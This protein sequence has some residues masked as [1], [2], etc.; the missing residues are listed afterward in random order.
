MLTHFEREETLKSHRGK[1]HE[2][3][4]HIHDSLEA[5]TTRSILILNEV[6]TSTTLK[7]SLFL[8]RRIMEQIAKL[9]ALCVCVTFLD[10]LASLGEKV[11]SLVCAV[12]P[13]DPSV[14]TFK[15]ERRPADGLAYARSL[16][17][18]HRLT[19]ENLEE[20]IGS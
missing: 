1:L 8:S 6:F 3:L 13:R 20:R 16:A 10:E 17:E 15:I 12:D 18:K 2:E 9:D 11:V 19:Y 5:A 4:I 14:R 7:D